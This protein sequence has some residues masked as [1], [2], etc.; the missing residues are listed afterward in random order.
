MKKNVLFILCLF[1][2]IKGFTQD[3]NPEV[4]ATSGEYFSGANGSL[5]WTIGEPVTETF[6]G[7]NAI[8]TQ[9]F[10]QNTYII[11]AIESM[12]DDDFQISVY[13][14]PANDLI[15]IHLNVKS[16]VIIELFD[17]QGKKLSCLPRSEGR[18]Y[19]GEKVAANTT[20]KQLNL[21]NFA[22]G[23]YILRITTTNGNLL[24]SYKIEKM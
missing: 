20:L 14:N 13:P 22:I 18:T 2:I 24:K 12:Q 7:V 5:S 17:I 6:S 16:D 23:S 21:N 8:L 3:L 10:Q 11:V 15:N 9:G 19:W 4:I 1:F